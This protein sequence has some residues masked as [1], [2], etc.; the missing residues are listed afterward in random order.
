MQGTS[1]RTQCSEKFTKDC[2]RRHLNVQFYYDRT[3]IKLDRVI[4]SQSKPPILNRDEFQQWK[5]RMVNFLEGNHPRIAEF[6][7]TVSS[8]DDDEKE[9]AGLA[10]K[11]K[12]LLIMALPNEIF[13]SLDHC[14]T[15]MELWLEIQRQIEEGVKT[16]K[17]NRTQY[18]STNTMSSRLKK[19]KL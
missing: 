19:E 16:V 3:C 10:A 18:V 9:I 7:H 11:C 14:N 2:S 15:S 17:N 12:R 6:L 13:E 8:W 5:I 1:D 4:G